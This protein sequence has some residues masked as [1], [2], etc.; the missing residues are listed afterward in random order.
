[1]WRNFRKLRTV[2]AV[3][4]QSKPLTLTE[5]QLGHGNDCTF[6]GGRKGSQ[7]SVIGPNCFSGKIKLL[8][9]ETPNFLNWVQQGF[10]AGLNLASGDE[11]NIV[12]QSISQGTLIFFYI[13][14]HYCTSQRLPFI[15][16]ER[17]SNRT[18]HI[19]TSASIFRGAI[20][21]N[22]GNTLERVQREM[23]PKKGFILC[24]FHM[25]MTVIN[26]LQGDLLSMKTCW[27]LVFLS[28]WPKMKEDD[29]IFSCSL[30]N[31]MIY[32]W[33]ATKASNQANNINHS[34]YEK[35]MNKWRLNPTNCHIQ[36]HARS[37][38]H[39]H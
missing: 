34:L 1:M 4:H 15:P 25:V 11:R 23:S 39:P 24:Y 33:L 8:F 22:H 26:M 9:L 16:T 13:M 6:S 38:L 35:L 2:S 21:N 18:Q 31:I 30:C 36:G 19:R 37:A 27:N 20:H 12:Y 10:S 7:P 3:T 28:L 32:K 14:F 17:K 5:W 29:S